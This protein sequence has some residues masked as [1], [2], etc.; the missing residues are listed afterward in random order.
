MAKTNV[1]Q[2]NNSLKKIF[3]EAEKSLKPHDLKHFKPFIN[4]FYSEIS[5]TNFIKHPPIELFNRAYQAWLHSKERKTNTPS[6]LVF[7]ACNSKHGFKSTNTIIEVITED[8]PFL[9]SSISS[10]LND[11]GL[12][13]HFL[14]HPTIYVRRSEDNKILEFMETPVPKFNSK[15]ESVIHLEITRQSEPQLKKIK[16]S[17]KLIKCQKT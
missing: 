11:E 17:L 2:R 10:A 14:V 8:M 13:I 4:M 5:K 6:V 15:K 7:N 12:I 9:V 1:R 16:N 3:K